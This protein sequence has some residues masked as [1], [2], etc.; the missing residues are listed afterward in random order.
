MKEMKPISNF[1][2]NLY[3]VAIILLLAYAAFSTAMKD[4]DRLHEVAGN[5]Q[6]ATSNGL[7]GLATVYS[8]TKSLAAGVEFAPA[9]LPQLTG[10]PRLDIVDAGGS[11]ALAGFSDSA[12]S[13]NISCPVRKRTLAK[14]IEIDKDRDWK[15]IAQVPRRVRFLHDDKFSMS[16]EAEVATLLRR[17]PRIRSIISK[18]P[19]AGSE[20]WTNV[21]EFKSLDDVIGFGFKMANME[22]AEKQP[23][24]ETSEPSSPFVFER[25]RGV[26]DSDSDNL[27]MRD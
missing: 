15:L 17:A 13:A 9:P 8:A 18:L 2:N 4:L 19:K 3:Q 21:D 26:S 25:R 20:R 12:A 24:V 27:E 10:S 1:K 22:D 23:S 5:V 7:G 16:T 6:S 14:P 11:V